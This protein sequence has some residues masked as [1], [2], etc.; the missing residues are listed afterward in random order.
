MTT[1]YG[2]KGNHSRVDKAGR[3]Q[4]L[5]PGGPEQVA[6]G[7]HRVAKVSKVAASD[8]LGDVR[9]AHRPKQELAQAPKIS[10]DGL[11]DSF[12]SA[13]ASVKANHPTF[14]VPL[15]NRTITISNYRAAFDDQKKEMVERVK[16]MIANTERAEHIATYSYMD[17]A[18]TSKWM[19][20]FTF[21]AKFYLDEREKLRTFLQNM[22]GETY[23]QYYLLY[24]ED[25]KVFDRV[26]TGGFHDVFMDKLKAA[27]A[28][29]DGMHR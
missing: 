12:G 27:A 18:G 20:N 24:K 25:P 23:P 16:K 1:S 9:L 17:Q 3:K 10:F 5:S 14:D 19:S 13:L 29:V 28:R 7:N 22:C 21:K 26:S 2:K 6:K 8:D 4:M 15:A 11:P